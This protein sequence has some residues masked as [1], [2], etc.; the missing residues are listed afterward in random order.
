MPSTS[1]A[2][3]AP[4]TARSRRSRL[5]PVAAK[6]PEITA[7]FWVIK[8][9]TT[10]MGEAASDGLGETSL[11]LGGV[12]GVGGF[13]LALWLQ[14]RSDRYHAPTYWFCVSMIAV[15]GTIVADVLHV[16]TGLSYYVT[17]AFYAGSVA[18][19]FT[20]W[21]RSEG[22]LSIHHIDT[23]RRERFYWATVLATFALG[24]AVGD[25]VGLTM[26]L[27][28]FAAGL[29]FLAAMMVPLVAWRLGANATLCFWTA[30]V[31]TRPLGASFADWIGKDH[32]IGGGLGFGDLRLTAIL[33][34]A[35]AVL[36]AYAHRSGH[37]IQRPIPV[38][39]DA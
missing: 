8:V 10:G 6:V 5:E 37:D 22:T 11:V 38:D 39:A 7:L 19:L 4:T 18:V 26:D 35:I 1:R 20:W 13:F 21:H 9:L 14:L 34:V 33:A 12:I 32:E 27:G 24:T 2:L 36:V 15:F 16:A 3:D 23:R 28:F 25:L 29:L 30:Y 17:S 31:L